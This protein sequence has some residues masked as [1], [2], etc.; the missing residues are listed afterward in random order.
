[1]VGKAGVHWVAEEGDTNVE[2]A[3][4]LGGDGGLVPGAGLVVKV[5]LPLGGDEVL[6][7]GAWVLAELLRLSLSMSGGF[8]Q[9]AVERCSEFVDMIGWVITRSLG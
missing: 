3:E 9:A 1:M 8:D 4:R 6:M 5:A 7:P 2:V